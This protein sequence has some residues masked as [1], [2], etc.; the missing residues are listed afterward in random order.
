MRRCSD[1]FLLDV[2][3]LEGRLREAVGGFGP[4][5]R[6]VS[7]L[8]IGGCLVSGSMCAETQMGS[9]WTCR[10]RREG[11]GRRGRVSFAPVSRPVRYLFGCCLKGGSTCG[12]S[13]GLLVDMVRLEGQVARGRAKASFRCSWCLETGSCK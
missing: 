3:G 8:F 11:C 9:F 2:V 4:V 7:S 1:G 5:P 12:C 13:D 10:V 6:L